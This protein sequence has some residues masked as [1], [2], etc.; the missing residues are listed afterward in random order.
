M[1]RQASLSRLGKLTLA[2]VVALLGA[3]LWK[4]AFLDGLVAPAIVSALV[5]LATAVGLAST[6]V[7]WMPALAVAVAAFAV[8]GALLAPRVQEILSDPGDVWP[9]VT[10]VIQLVGGTVAVVAGIGA[11]AQNYRAPATVEG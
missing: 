5:F 4:I 6:A 1:E 11:T 10:S 7:R 8:G 9:F 2:G 3:T